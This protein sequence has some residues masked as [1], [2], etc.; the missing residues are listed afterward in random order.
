MLTFNFEEGMDTVSWCALF[1]L[2]TRDSMS[3]MGSVM[4]IVDR[5]PFSLRFLSTHMSAARSD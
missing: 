4:V 3:A 1:A 5:L 2:R